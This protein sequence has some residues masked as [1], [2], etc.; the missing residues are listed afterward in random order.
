[1]TNLVFRCDSSYSIGSGHLMRCLNLAKQIGGN[2]TFICR[3]LKGNLNVKVEENQF[4]LIELEG[5]PSLDLQNEISE[6]SPILQSL[7]PQTLIID[8]YQL[9]SEWEL[10][11]KKYCHKVIAL[12]DL[13]REH[14][15]DAI[16]DQNFYLKP[17]KLYSDFTG[18]KFIGPQYCLLNEHFLA[19]KDISRDHT[20]L[21]SIMIFF[22]GADSAGMTLK[23][24][25]SI[26]ENK[27]ASRGFSYQVV[28]G[29][30][31]TDFDEIQKA[32]FASPE[33]L[34]LHFN[35]NYMH[36]LMVKSDL[37][38]GAGGT[39][40]W[41]RAKVLLPSIVVSI[42]EN[43]EVV[44]QELSHIGA[45]KYLGKSTE[46]KVESIIQEILNLNENPTIMKKM[47]EASLKLEV[48]KSIG[49]FISYVKS[50]I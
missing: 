15:V 49:R 16:L 37:F 13:N 29:A 3:K 24:L 19:L 42:A 5:V 40:S 6:A 4:R 9:G 50:G 38:I 45:I 12:D 1:M 28:V 21:N 26:L 41:E 25:N 22:G 39:T 8:H 48:S 11:V 20:K 35:I 30:Q 47:I 44:C 34:K 17:E 18:E 23:L 36:E 43:Q 33:K 32:C 14:K 7:A 2:P 27:E 10:A 46:V 31:N